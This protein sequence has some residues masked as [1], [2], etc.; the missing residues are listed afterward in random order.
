MPT[1]Y[2]LRETTKGLYYIRDKGW[3]GETEAEAT[4]LTFFEMEFRQGLYSKKPHRRKK[5]EI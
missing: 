1:R 5:I 4:K 2:I 3:V